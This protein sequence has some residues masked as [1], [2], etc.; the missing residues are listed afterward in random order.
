MKQTK[1]T[2][3][4]FYVP[5]GMRLFVEAKVDA[6]MRQAYE[7]WRQYDGAAEEKLGWFNVNVHYSHSF[8]AVSCRAKYTIEGRHWNDGEWWYSDL[9]QSEVNDVVTFCFDDGGGK[10]DREGGNSDQDYSTKNDQDYNDLV[11]KCRK[12]RAIEGD[13]ALP[14]AKERCDRNGGR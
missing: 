4:S 8:A 5:A 13:P 1:Q 12:V 7:M 11:I 6:S 10:D 2:K 9:R 3:G 14:Q